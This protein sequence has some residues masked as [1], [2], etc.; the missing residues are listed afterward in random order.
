MSAWPA[1]GGHQPRGVQA[2]ALVLAI[3]VLG[4]VF[5]LGTW[6]FVSPPASA[7]ALA[8][9][10]LAPASDFA[11]G[12]VTSYRIIDGRVTEWQTDLNRYRAAVAGSRGRIQGAGVFY[13]VRLPDGDFRVLSGRSTH[14]GGLVVWDTSGDVWSNSSY[15]GVFIEP[16]HSEQW[17]ADGT[18]VYGPAPRDLD[19]Y[20]WH[21]DDGGVLVLDLSEAIEG[22]RD[23]PRPPLY[24]VLDP[25]WP[26]SGWPATATD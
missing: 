5:V 14:L 7:S 18:R 12:S 10:R 20:A 24:D 22:D 3:A 11:P 2:V 19:R 9:V 15:V 25:A 4:G 16:A 21:V 26:T 13:V 6:R 8:D 1:E 23:T 17:T